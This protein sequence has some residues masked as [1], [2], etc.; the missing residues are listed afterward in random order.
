MAV[1]G[2]NKGID[3]SEEIKI[4]S[5]ESACGSKFWCHVSSQLQL[6][7]NARE[8]SRLG[9]ED[10]GMRCSLVGKKISKYPCLTKNV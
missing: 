10:I 3:V 9:Y 8:H 1:I 4:W 6:R 7:D 2:L 5:S